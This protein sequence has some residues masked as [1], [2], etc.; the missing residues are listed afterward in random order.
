MAYDYLCKQIT[1]EYLMKIN[2]N[3]FKGIKLQ[4]FFLSV[5]MIFLFIVSPVNAFSTEIE[6]EDSQAQDIIVVPP[7][8]P[9]AVYEL[10]S[11]SKTI[12]GEQPHF[13]KMTISLAYEADS[14][15]KSELEARGDELQAIINLLLR[16]KKYKE[17][18]SVNGAITLSEEIKAH[19]NMRLIN[20]K[21]KEVYFKEFVVN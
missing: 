3:I 5:S 12:T 19:I 9:L 15:F 14:V 13:I 8:E 10:P 16:G 11:F 1:K 4:Y 18:D 2:K 20:G 7:P 6:S 17:L 21:I